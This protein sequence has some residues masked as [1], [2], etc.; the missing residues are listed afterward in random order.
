MI[1]AST[2]CTKSRWSYSNRA[3][4]SDG[5]PSVNSNVPRRLSTRS[6]VEID[7][8]VSAESPCRCVA[9]LTAVNLHHLRRASERQRGHHPARARGRRHADSVKAPLIARVR[10]RRRR[11]PRISRD[12]RDAGVSD[13]SVG[14]VEQ[15]SQARSGAGRLGLLLSVLVI[16]LGRVRTGGW[17]GCGLHGAAALSGHQRRPLRRRRR[18]ETSSPRS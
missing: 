13:L 18:R 10:R 16:S 17:V 3:V 2:P 1:N 7:A 6:G 12:V 14:W 4:A 5:A 9:P 11:R 15:D 8:N